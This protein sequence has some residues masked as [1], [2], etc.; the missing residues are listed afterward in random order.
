MPSPLC[1]STDCATVATTP[2]ALLPGRFLAQTLLWLPKVPQEIRSSAPRTTMRARPRSPTNSG[3][4]FSPSSSEHLPRLPHCGPSR[5]SQRVRSFPDSFELGASWW[6]TKVTVASATSRVCP[7]KHIANWGG[8]MPAHCTRESSHTHSDGALWNILTNGA[9]SLP[10]STLVNPI[11]RN[12]CPLVQI[13]QTLHLQA[14]VD[15][16]H[17]FGEVAAS[18]AFPTCWAMVRATNLLPNFTIFT[19]VSRTS[20]RASFS[21]TLKN[22]CYVRMSLH[23][24]WK[25]SIAIPDTSRR[26][27]TSGPQI[28]RQQLLIQFKWSSWDVSDRLVWQRCSRP[29][30]PTMGPST[31][32]VVVNA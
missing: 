11:H 13:S 9:A 5:P 21:A 14:F 7:L 24:G 19:T 29:G 1:N 25:C 32:S 28:A 8:W 2:C 31:C 26:P 3:C 20:P 17:W 12:D 27:T 23:K 30:T 10:P 18:K 4:K 15:N 6:V 16:A 22:T